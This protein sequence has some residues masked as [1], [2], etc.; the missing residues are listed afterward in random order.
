[1]E[2]V[3][4]TC[5]QWRQ[6]TCDVR[7]GLFA[8][9]RAWRMQRW[10]IPALWW[11]QQHILATPYLRFSKHWQELNLLPS[12]RLARCGRGQT[13]TNTFHRKN[14]ST[15]SFTITYA[16]QIAADAVILNLFAERINRPCHLIPDKRAHESLELLILIMS[17]FV[18]FVLLSTLI[19]GKF[20]QSTIRP[21]LCLLSQGR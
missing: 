14:K 9:V 10:D 20:V 8:G 17:G 5:P 3:G 11:W 1:M 7:R 4:V 18:C 13:N 19:F 2:Y 21:P 6:S 12:Y 15:L 16:H